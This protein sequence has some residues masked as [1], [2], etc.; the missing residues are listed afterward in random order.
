MFGPHRPLTVGWQLVHFTGDETTA[1]FGGPE[2]ERGATWDLILILAP[3]PYAMQTFPVLSLGFPICSGG[4]Q[5]CNAGLVNSAVKSACS[6]WDQ[7]DPR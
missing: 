1:R 3:P 4:G 7:H 5:A 2:G 6:R